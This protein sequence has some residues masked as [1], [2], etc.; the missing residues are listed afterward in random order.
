[1]GILSVP[2][3][4]KFV[5]T[6]LD[7]DAILLL[8]EDAEDEIIERHGELTTQTDVINNANLST[9]LFLSRIAVTI[10][11]VTEELISG[12]DVDSLLL[13]SSDYRLRENGRQID[14]LSD[15]VNS[16][17]VW[18]DTVNIVFV[19]KDDKIRRKRVTVDLVRLAINYNAAKSER[20]GDFNMTSVDYERERSRLIGRLESWPWA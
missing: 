16:R 2:E 11:S 6:D 9:C 17:S 19:P 14:R 10:T 7:S 1:M 8:I 5:E 3:V 15:G 20:S 18:G 4:K 12:G 13:A